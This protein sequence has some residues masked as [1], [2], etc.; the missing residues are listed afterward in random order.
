M[1]V[2]GGAVI[3]EIIHFGVEGVVLQKIYVHLG[4]VS[5]VKIRLVLLLAKTVFGLLLTEVD[6]QIENQDLTQSIIVPGC[7]AQRLLADGVFNVVNEIDTAGTRI[8]WTQVKATVER[9]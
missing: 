5:L 7:T 6:T 9:L 8:I 2:R 1:K 3:N 4:G